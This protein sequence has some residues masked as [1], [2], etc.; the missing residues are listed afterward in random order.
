MQAKMGGPYGLLIT[1]S[2]AS[3]QQQKRDTHTSTSSQSKTSYEER[4]N[5]SSAE[6]GQEKKRIALY[7][8]SSFLRVNPCLLV[9]LSLLTF[10]RGFF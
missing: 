4:E 10:V 5:R 1:P 2:E 8:V 3:Q 9:R 7:V 6:F